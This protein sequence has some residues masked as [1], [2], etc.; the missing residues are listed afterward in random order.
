MDHAPIVYSKAMLD[1]LTVLMRWL[2]I[3]SMA[4]LVGGIL[5]GRLIVA[6][7]LDTLPAGDREALGDRAAARYRPFVVAAL[8]GLIL[9][10]VY[11]Y[12]ITPGHRAVYQM[13]FG[14][15]L[16]LVAHVFAVAIL[17]TKPHNPRRTRMMTGVAVSG[18][19]IILISAW[20]RSTY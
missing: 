3:S 17:I 20:L 1:I 15:K 7:A 13:L 2:H 5:Y 14:V 12:L 6:P 18:L 9:S 8:I 19:A 16:L 10:G 4:T 11:K